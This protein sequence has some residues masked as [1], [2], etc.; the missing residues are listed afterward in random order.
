M[1]KCIHTK[2][3][4]AGM[5]RSIWENKE[6]YCMLY[7]LMSTELQVTFNIAWVKFGEL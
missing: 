4:E 3:S 6:V 7:N 5:D 1:L 2:S